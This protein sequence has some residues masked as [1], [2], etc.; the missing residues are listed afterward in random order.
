MLTVSEIW[1][2]VYDVPFDDLK[3][4][5]EY[6]QCSQSAFIRRFSFRLVRAIAPIDLFE[7]ECCE[8]ISLKRGE[9]RGCREQVIALALVIRRYCEL[10]GAGNFRIIF[11]YISVYHLRHYQNEVWI[12]M[13]EET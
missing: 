8:L 4:E 2:I 1:Q 6:V 3:R 10:I 12:D 9:S 7:Q 11:R 5:V 13:D